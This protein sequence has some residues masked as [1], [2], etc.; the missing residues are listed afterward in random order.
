MA[1]KTAYIAG[2]LEQHKDEILDRWRDA[3]RQEQA[4]A[5]RLFKMDDRELLDTCLRLPRH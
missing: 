2:Y 1:A 4:Q 3:A 5:E